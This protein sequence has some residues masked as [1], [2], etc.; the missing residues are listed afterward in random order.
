[1]RKPW[2]PSDDRELRRIYAKHSAAECAVA[3]ARTVSAIQQRVSV[4]G[5]SKS[6]EWIAE[7]ARQRWAEGRHDASRAPLAAGRGWNKGIKGS[8]G[9]HPN[10]RRTQ[11]KKGRAPHLARNYQPIGSLRLSK[12]GYLERKVTDDHP[13]PARR[14]IG[15]HRLVWEAAHG[16]VPAGHA[17]VFKPGRRSASLDSI[18]PDAVE[19]VS[20]AEL[21]R[22]NT[23]HRFPKELADLI[24]MKGALTR[25][26]NNRV[27]EAQTP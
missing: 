3:L 21:M 23:R 9:L 8:T 2:K 22:R 14:W 24:A 16:P 13:V 25:R 11:F 7:R 4:L 20:R 19:L 18:T 17:V 15:V 10:C 27:K 12:D 5:L 6:P 1:M 26:I